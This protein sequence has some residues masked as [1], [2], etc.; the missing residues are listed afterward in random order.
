MKLILSRLPYSEHIHCCHTI[1]LSAVLVLWQNIWLFLLEHSSLQS[2]SVP[3]SHGIAH[4]SSPNGTVQ[5][6]L[7]Y[8]N[9]Y[10]SEFI[11]LLFMLNNSLVGQACTTT[12]AHLVQTSFLWAD[13]HT[14][15]YHPCWSIR[16]QI[17]HPINIGKHAD[18][19]HQICGNCS[20]CKQNS[21]T[22]MARN[23]RTYCAV[24]TPSFGHM[25]LTT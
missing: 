1:I 2:A 20:I 23:C 18:S 10:S 12:S 13:L 9:S 7:W 21:T 14:L 22:W 19:L 16:P 25:G 15:D 8:S 3:V 4:L 24:D 17:L 11:F 6:C 5:T